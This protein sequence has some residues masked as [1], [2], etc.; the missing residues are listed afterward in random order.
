MIEIAT[1]SFTNI[2]LKE[3]DDA[4]TFYNNVL[5]SK[6]PNILQSAYGQKYLVFTLNPIVDLYE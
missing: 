1:S 5:Y 3:K 2:F 6:L 4:S